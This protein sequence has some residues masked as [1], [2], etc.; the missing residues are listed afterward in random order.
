[1]PCGSIITSLLDPP[2]TAS[3]LARLSV[4]DDP[5]QQGPIRPYRHTG[6]P[7]RGLAATRSSKH[8]RAQWLLGNVYLI[9][10]RT[11]ADGQRWVMVLRRV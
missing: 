6:K 7:L 4:I 11:P 2:A 5:T 8:A 9:P 3:S 10:S 1:M